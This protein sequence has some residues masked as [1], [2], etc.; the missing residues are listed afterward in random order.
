MV[1]VSFLCRFVVFDGFYRLPFR[2]FVPTQRILE[3]GH[4]VRQGKGVGFVVFFE[5]IYPLFVGDVTIRSSIVFVIAIDVTD[6]FRPGVFRAYGVTAKV[7]PAVSFQTQF[8]LA[9][10]P[11]Q[12]DQIVTGS[13][14]GRCNGEAFCL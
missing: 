7:I 10:L 6:D 9:F 11:D 2:T 14:H 5:F 4:F 1:N 3:F 13:V 8:T 12:I